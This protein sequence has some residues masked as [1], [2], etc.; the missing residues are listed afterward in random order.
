VTRKLLLIALLVAPSL[1][2]GIVLRGGSFA[3]IERPAVAA[4]AEEW[5]A[6]LSLDGGAYYAFRITPHLDIDRKQFTW[7]VPNVETKN[8][9]IL[10]RAGNERRE[11]LYEQPA[12]FAIEA[13]AGA[14]APH[15]T[16]VPS[17]GE[18]AREGDPGVAAW[19]DGDRAGGALVVRTAVPERARIAALH[20]QRERAEVA[21]AHAGLLV[22][23]SW[24]LVHY[25]AQTKNQEL[26]TNN[27]EPLDI[28]LQTSRLNI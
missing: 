1:Q 9:R 5:E 28:L 21:V 10:I 20:V 25:Q 3:T 24:F 11:T 17:R 12:T 15:T 14:I 26:R 2:A 27:P 13:G 16:I 7:V 22:L 6:F 19:I 8:A 18:A 4:S 23:S